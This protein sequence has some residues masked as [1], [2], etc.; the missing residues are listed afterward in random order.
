MAALR[1][2]Q[3]RGIRVEVH[4]SQ[5]KLRLVI[6]PTIIRIY[7]VAGIL[8]LGAILIGLFSFV[9]VNVF[10][11]FNHTWVR[12]VVLSP[13]HQKVIDASTSLADARL[14]A[15]QFETER[16]EV[17]AE[18]AQIDRVVAI[19]DKFLID[20]SALPGSD[21]KTPLKSVEAGLLRRQIDEATLE[22]EHAIGRRESLQQRSKHMVL[23][24]SEQEQ[25]VERLASSPYLRAV[26][27]KVVIVFIPYTNLPNIQVGTKLYGCSWGLALCSRVGRV[28]SIL[29]G[30]VQELH[31]HDESVQRGVMAEI[32]LSKDTAGGDK[33]LFAG[34]KPLWLL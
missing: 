17:A 27:R 34:G 11:F 9:V 7:K 6:Q 16:L 21:A 8:A 1:C 33:V 25:L 10:Y 12:P 19:V 24:I 2:R 31:P 18:I 32:A 13:T 29:E 26:E 23:R 30:E 22:R 5:G 15:S 14:R 28:I 4:K 20:V 3:P